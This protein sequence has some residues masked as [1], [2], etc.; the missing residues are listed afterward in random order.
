[1]PLSIEL[2]G[3]LLAAAIQFSGLPPIDVS[4]L[5]PV[6]VVSNSE[7]A[8]MVCPTAPARC[9]ALV[10]AFDTMRYRI[11]VRD[12]I[13]LDQPADNSFL[14]HE[15]VHVLQYKRDGNGRFT[16]CEA[17][18]AS[19]REA[20]DAQNR[21][22]KSYGLRWQEGTMLRLVKCPP[23]GPGHDGTADGTAGQRQISTQGSE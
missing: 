22:I 4:E 18:V 11:V 12:S 1:M 2:L 5:P 7:M 14:V 16:S 9:A 3:Q 21:Y 19:E 20:Y 8:H 23:S 15:I 13:D 17:V 6:L 10:A